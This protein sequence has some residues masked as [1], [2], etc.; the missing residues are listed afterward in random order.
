MG[1]SQ[2]ALAH[3]LVCAFPLSIVL[4]N[5]F[6]LIICFSAMFMGKRHLDYKSEEP[7]LPV[8]ELGSPITGAEQKEQCLF[9]SVELFC[10]NSSLVS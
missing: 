1:Q 4:Y 10:N 8:K 5:T 6:G 2:S 3:F 9:K 7:Q